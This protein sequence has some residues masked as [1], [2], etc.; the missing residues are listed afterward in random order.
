MLIYG[1]TQ[2]PRC[3]T[4]NS[5]Y[6]PKEVCQEVPIWNKVKCHNCNNEFLHVTTK[7]EENFNGKK[8]GIEEG[9]G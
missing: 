9:L 5:M 8:S 6:R 2:C 3:K 7:K 1:Q 4:L